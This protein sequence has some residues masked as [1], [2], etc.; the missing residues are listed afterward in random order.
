[1]N[2]LL[3]ISIFMMIGVPA[4][5]GTPFTLEDAVNGRF[6][7]ERQ[8]SVTPLG[9]GERYA[10]LSKG[11]V[12]SYSFRNGGQDGVLFDPATAKGVAIE[13]AESFVMSPDGAKMLIATEVQYIYRR[14]FT[15][16]WYIYDVKT[17]TL[18]RLSSAPCQSPVWSNDGNK[19]AY[20]RD[21]N[22]F[23]FTVNDSNEI[24]VTFDGKRNEVIN[25]IPDWVNEEE[26]GFSCSLCFNADCSQI[27]WIK[28]DESDVQTF[29]LQL[30]KGMKPEIDEYSDYPGCYSY[31]YPKAG[32]ANAKVSAWTYDLKSGESRRLHVPL[33][34]DGYICRLF[35][36]PN[37]SS[38]LFVTLNR[39]Q[40][41]MCVY[42][43]NPITAK[44][45]LILQEEVNKYVPEV[46]YDLMLT[47]NGFLMVSDRDNY[48]HIYHYSM[49]GKLLQKV[50]P[51]NIDITAVYGMDKKT[52]DIYYQAAPTPMTRHI[53][54]AHRNGRIEKLSK[55]DGTNSATFSAT[56]KYY[57]NTWSDRNTPYVCTSNTNKGKLLST[58]IDN[59]ELCDKLSQYDMPKKD[60]FSFTTSEGVVL[61]GWMMRPSNCSSRKCPVI[62]HQ[63]SGPSSQQVL[64]S[65]RLGS[66][67][68]G[69]IYDAYLCSLGFIVVTVDGR[70]TGCR[71]AE[72]E[73]CTYLNLGVLESKDQVEA[74][75][76]LARQDYVDAD[77]IGI[78][79]WSYGGFNTLM[80]MSEGRGVFYAGVAIA[81]P[82]NWK[83]YDSV[84]TERFMRT[85]QENP[86]GYAENPISRVSKLHGKLLLCH[87]TADDNV[88]PQNSYEYAEALVQAD[89]DF[90]ELLYTN[91]NH[92]IFGGNTRRHLLRQVAGHFVDA[93]K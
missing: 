30:Y 88:H 89:K 11:K 79:G 25:G 43:A 10:C 32:Y 15:A 69:A 35:Q 16:V 90:R 33:D 77:H 1:M 55:R 82:T 49:D 9:D 28:Y 65:W 17:N 67:G 20:V 24:Q 51:E 2:K 53:Y 21:N 5:A 44:A 7:A 41:R 37:A 8:M 92:S 68:E 75:L 64:D 87:G 12:L 71:G 6:R 80:S 58:I 91:R 70:G 73:K 59:K 34:A 46:A 57:F 14:S 13:M 18:S 31:K 85:P 62:M 61:N 66:M 47:D 63:Y 84:Y 45:T 60:F 48:R 29:E 23:L 38:V 4:F 36:T 78:W 50:C 83:F 81:P 72:F 74:A 54:V 76:W 3:I 27:C 42:A 93:M 52:G 22:I 86:A 19:I 26:F 40:D 56:M 39:H